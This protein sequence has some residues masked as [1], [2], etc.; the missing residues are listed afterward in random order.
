M[1][2]LEPMRDSLPGRAECEPASVTCIEMLVHS[3]LTWPQN[4]VLEVTRNYR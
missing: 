3:Q 4:L 2:S 1:G